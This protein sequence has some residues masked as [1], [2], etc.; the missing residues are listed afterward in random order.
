MYYSII[1]IHYL[2]SNINDHTLNCTHLTV[3]QQGYS[4]HDFPVLA[5]HSPS[6]HTILQSVAPQNFSSSSIS[7]SRTSPSTLPLVSF[8][9]QGTAT[10]SSEVNILQGQFS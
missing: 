6:L 4:R 1:I 3:S 9:S 2:I 7:S 5:H 10:S 8:T